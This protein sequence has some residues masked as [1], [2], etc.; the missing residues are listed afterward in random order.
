MRVIAGQA[1]GHRLKAPKASSTRPTAGKIKGALFAM[2]E[3]MLRADALHEVDADLADLWA[4]R[5]VLDLYAGTGALGIEALSR[6]AAFADF[7]EARPHC[8]QLIAQNLCH[9]G[10]SARGGV[11]CVSVAHFLR[12]A[13]SL[14]P[15]PAYDIILM[16]PPYADPDLAR[17]V[18]E[19]AASALVR[20]AAL[21][22]V[23]HWRRVPLEDAYGN[24]RRIRAR[25]HGDTCVSIYLWCPELGGGAKVHKRLERHCSLAS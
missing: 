8:C 7:V 19:V 20:S 14:A 17:T 22:A 4:G 3:S 25:R 23:L 10:L 1:K 13:S 12:A 9:T 6:G 16:D 11:H 15:P 5:R 2:V 18:G 21:L 24:L